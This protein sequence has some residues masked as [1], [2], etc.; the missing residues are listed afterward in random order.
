VIERLRQDGVPLP[1]RAAGGPPRRERELL[2][3]FP[4]DRLVVVSEDD[5][6]EPLAEQLALFDR[7][8]SRWTLK[9]PPE[10]LA[11]AVAE[12]REEVGDRTHTYHR[13]RALAMWERPPKAPTG[14]ATGGPT[15]AGPD[16]AAPSQE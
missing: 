5:V 10:K 2:A 7:R 15:P 4:P 13:V 14:S 8:A 1:D 9:V 16:G 11:R 3:Q 6:T 12:A